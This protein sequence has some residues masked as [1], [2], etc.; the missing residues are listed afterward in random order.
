MQT[1]LTNYYQRNHWKQYLQTTTR[2]I[3]ANYTYKSLWDNSIHY[4]QYSLSEAH[5]TD[6]SF[7]TI[8]RKFNT[9]NAFKSCLNPTTSKVQGHIACQ[10]TN[11]GA[12]NQQLQQS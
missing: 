3:I 2:E 5:D 11:F 7:K 1:I 12:D 8:I 6:N 9:D 10:N 4:K